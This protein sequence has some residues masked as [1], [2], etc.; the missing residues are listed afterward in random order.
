MRSAICWIFESSKATF[1]FDDATATK[2]VMH[3]LLSG[4]A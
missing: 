2:F 3:P 1:N 4:C